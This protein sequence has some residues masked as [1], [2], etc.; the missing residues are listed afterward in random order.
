MPPKH[1]VR[2][3]NPPGRAT[4]PNKTKGFLAYRETHALTKTLLV[5]LRF[6]FGDIFCRTRKGREYNAEMD[7]T[8]A[9][10][11]L[12]SDLKQHGWS[13]RPLGYDMVAFF[14][15]TTLKHRESPYDLPALSKALDLGLLEKCTVYRVA[16]RGLLEVMEYYTSRG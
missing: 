2:G 1:K 15:P 4:F 12:V 14:D 9:A 13:A 6:T 5:Y 10:K 8:Q 16:G 7:T 11:S 3:S